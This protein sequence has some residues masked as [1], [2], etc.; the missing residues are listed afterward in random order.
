MNV[1]PIVLL[2]LVLCAGCASRAVVPG[3][4]GNREL[5]AGVYDVEF[6]SAGVRKNERIE[7]ELQAYEVVMS[8]VVTNQSPADSFTRTKHWVRIDGV[9]IKGS[10]PVVVRPAGDGAEPVITGAGGMYTAETRGASHSAMFGRRG[11]FGEW[12]MNASK[13]EGAVI[14]HEAESLAGRLLEVSDAAQDGALLRVVPGV[15]VGITRVSQDNGVFSASVRYWVSR[16]LRD[17]RGVKRLLAP[18]VPITYGV[19]DHADPGGRVGL[20]P[21]GWELG[22]EAVPVLLEIQFLNEAGEVVYSQP[23]GTAAQYEL[24]TAM[25]GEI[26]VE[27]PLEAGERVVHFNPVSIVSERQIEIPFSVDLD[28][29]KNT[30]RT[31]PSD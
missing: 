30:T 2:A 4:T 13:I 12:A 3:H 15:Y 28:G 26:D 17:A 6:R 31:Q 24:D 5:G 22:D 10:A 1:L 16:P 25:L 21:R 7:A 27:F 8:G 29:F 18:S 14:V 11:G 19:R 9:S 20:M 23:E